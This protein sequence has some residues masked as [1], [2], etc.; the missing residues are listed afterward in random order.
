MKIER[1]RELVNLYLDDEISKA[2]LQEFSRELALNPERKREFQERCR[3]DRALGLVFDPDSVR[4]VPEQA[5]SR[6]AYILW[7]CGLAACFTLSTVL[8]QPFW[9]GAVDTVNISQSGV[10]LQ[11]SDVLRTA[12][13]ERIARSHAA[14]VDAELVSFTAHLRLLGLRPE[15]TPSQ[16]AMQTVSHASLQPRDTRALE[17]ER[18]NR[19]PKHRTMP[20]ATVYQALPNDGAETLRF[21]GF[22]TSLAGFR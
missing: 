12:D 16:G 8:V 4:T 10:D 22:Q 20:E 2:E 17:L 9:S 3:L 13:F 7:G 18:F 14:P 11:N 5:M 21:G 15:I 19:W 1:F 6:S